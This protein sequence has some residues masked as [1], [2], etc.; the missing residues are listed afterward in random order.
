MKTY[1]VTGCTGF[2]ASNLVDYLL[3]RNCKIIGLDNLS[4]GKKFFLK[5]ALKNKNFK[6]YKIDLLKNNIDKYFENVDRVYHFAANADVRFGLKHRKKDINQN[7]IV[8]YKILETIK[9]NKINELIFA[10]TGSIYGEATQIP[11][12]EN[13]YFPIQTSLYGASKV[14][15]E[16]IISAYSE[17][18]E[19]KSYIF[20]FVSIL[21]DRY[22]HGHV[23]DFIKKLKKN[24]NVI[25]ILGDGNQKKSYLHVADCIRAIDLAVKKFN[26]KVNIVNL[27]TQECLT[28]KDSI[29]IICKILKLKPKMQYSGG[30]RGWIGDNPYI[31][32]DTYK[33]RSIGW[34]PR[35][36]IKRSIKKTVNYILKN[37]WLLKIKN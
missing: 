9:K 4:T 19:L 35:Y 8:T 10:S 15:A 2:I 26:K 12:K 1:L 3:K 24:K 14:S 11:T 5:E 34:E 33:I 32:L 29:K 21:G 22:N 23:Y 28:V 36:N 13:T 37:E 7:I 30:K 6:F 18:Y 27:G 25:N 20:R 17:A 16:A 31:Y